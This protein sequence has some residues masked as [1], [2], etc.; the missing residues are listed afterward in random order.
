MKVIQTLQ[1][2]VDHKKAGELR[3]VFVK[4]IKF[5]H[6]W[7]HKKDCMLHLSDTMTLALSMECAQSLILKRI[8]KKASSIS[9]I[10][11]PLLLA[12]PTENQ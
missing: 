10:P 7:K 3:M 8:L 9:Y 6:L 1:I 12:K 5:A 11:P 4:A 2:F